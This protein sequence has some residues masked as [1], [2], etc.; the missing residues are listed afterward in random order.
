MV[1]TSVCVFNFND[2]CFSLRTSVLVLGQVFLGLG[3][4]FLG[5]EQVFLGQ[6]QVVF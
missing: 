6:G 1:R 4:V 2:K 3:H 5:L